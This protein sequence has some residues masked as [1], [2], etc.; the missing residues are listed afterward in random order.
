MTLGFVA[1]PTIEDGDSNTLA[2]FT[3]TGTNDN[4]YVVD[5]TEPRVVS[6]T[7]GGVVSDQSTDF[8]N[9]QINLRLSKAITL[10]DLASDG[11]KAAFAVAVDNTN[12]DILR[13]T[14]TETSL[15]IELSS[16]VTSANISV[17]LSYDQGTA[18]NDALVDAA[19]N[20]VA[21][22]MRFII[23][24]NAIPINNAPINNAPTVANTI[25]DQDA[26]VGKEF[27]FTVPDNTFTDTDTGDT[28]TYTATLAGGDPLPGW[29][30]FNTN[31]GTFRG[32]PTAAETL[33]VRVTA[34]DGAASVFD[35]FVITVAAPAPCPES[36][37]EADGRRQIR[38]GTLTV[39][40]HEIST[41]MTVYGYSQLFS[42]ESLFDDDLCE[43]LPDEDLFLVDEEPSE[44]PQSALDNTMF[45][46]GA[47]SYSIQDAFAMSGAPND[48]DLFFRLSSNLTDEEVAALRLHVCDT[49]YSLNANDSPNSDW[50]V[51]QGCGPCLFCVQPASQ[52]G[53]RRGGDGLR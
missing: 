29:L 43:D 36:N 23:V 20:L 8:Q 40:E 48:G 53:Q 13:V 47:N 33:T 12:R 38:T 49:A 24:S 39:E 52:L 45:T 4:T 15:V 5:N 17:R 6:S 26:T 32:T 18:G 37:F 42:D 35:D 2:S 27:S 10:T 7:L 19:G 51:A 25:M 31:M 28:L 22:F 16:P 30:R 1:S 46:I 14:G 3:P 50:S 21:S 9:T 34:T 44:S 41:D 11:L